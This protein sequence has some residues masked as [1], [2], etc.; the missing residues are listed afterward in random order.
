VATVHIL[1]PAQRYVFAVSNGEAEA[2]TLD[3]SAD[4]FRR[5][6]ELQ[7]G[8]RTAGMVAFPN[9]LLVRG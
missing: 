5:Y 1:V 4:G 8:G 9:T 6:K 7:A 2:A 3:S